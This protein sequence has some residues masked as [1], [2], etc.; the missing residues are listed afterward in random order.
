MLEY[1]RNS[2][3]FV[4]SVNAIHSIFKYLGYSFTVF[5]N[6]L[7]KLVNATLGKKTDP[8]KDD[9]HPS[10]QMLNIT[11]SQQQYHEETD[12]GGQKA[13]TRKEPAR[14]FLDGS[15]DDCDADNHS[16]HCYS[17]NSANN[18]SVKTQPNA[19]TFG[20]NSSTRTPYNSPCDSSDQSMITFSET[21]FTK[22]VIAD[23]GSQTEKQAKT[24][25]ADT[26]EL[27][28]LRV[29]PPPNVKI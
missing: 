26:E 10:L 8:K 15:F 23:I 2:G 13:A 18:P 19:L 25:D 5:Y 24:S 21:E 1:I 22:A 16:R 4:S 20:F 7:S 28:L 3:P 17:P 27:G 14:P 29:P 11:A 12:L 6:K 9:D